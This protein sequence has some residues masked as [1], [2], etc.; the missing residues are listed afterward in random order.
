M[1]LAWTFLAVSVTSGVVQATA[2]RRMLHRPHDDH[3][4]G[5]L[6][7]TSACRVVAALA[8]VVLATVTLADPQT[9]AVP[10][11]A[12]FTAVQLMWITNGVLDVRLRRRLDTPPRHRR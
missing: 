6:L 8:Y 10:A 4:T 12:T 9:G 3:V 7:R 2:L 5:A 11:V 1:T